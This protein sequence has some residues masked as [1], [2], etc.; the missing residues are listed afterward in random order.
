MAFS[1]DLTARDG[2][3]EVVILSTCNRAEIY[4]MTRH[5]DEARAVIEEGLGRCIR[6]VRR[7]HSHAWLTVMCTRM[8]SVTCFA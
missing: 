5:P 8:Q 4:S 2:I 7:G 6:R 3:E 1:R